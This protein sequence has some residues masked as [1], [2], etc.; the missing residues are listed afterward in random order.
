MKLRDRFRLFLSSVGLLIL[1]FDS[2]TALT[3]IQEGIELCLRTLI[4]SLF[5]FCVF[6][7]MLT[8]T[9]LGSKIRI[10]RPI[11]KG[12]RIP[13]GS[14]SLLII[15]WLGGYPIGAQSVADAYHNGHLSPHDA[16]KLAIV[17][18]NPGPAFLF[19]VLGTIIPGRRYLFLLWMVQILSSLLVAL[20][21]PGSP[22]QMKSIRRNNS[23]PFTQILKKSSISMVNICASVVL[24][25]MVLEFAQ[26][27]FLWAVPDQ[28][29]IILSGI[30]ELS[31]GC[32]RLT[33]VSDP[34]IQLILASGLLCFG[35]FCVWMQTISVCRGLT[36]SRYLI[37]KTVQSILC[38]SITSMVVLPWQK[39]I[40]TFSV[41]ISLL[42]YFL[43][44]NRKKGIAFGKAL[45]YNKKSAI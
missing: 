39:S 13:E 40:Y 16:R 12:F 34:A 42:A 9:M 23:T 26:R 43:V 37:W 44:S 5:P 7:T 19:G 31:N 38:M 22:Q 18:N 10:F 27:W 32:I 24:F 21:I 33:D 15:G 3:G 4:P 29:S 2:R 8:E 36:I 6:G 20:M 28:C 11:S 1:I 30:L 45:L 14:E 25:R 17:C 41:F 35:G